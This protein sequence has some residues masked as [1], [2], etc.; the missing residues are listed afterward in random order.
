LQ[1]AKA[2]GNDKPTFAFG[3]VSA[4]LLSA[5]LLPQFYEIWK[6]KEV[7]GLSLTFMAVDLGGGV[8]CILSL[9]FKKT[10][11]PVATANYAGVVILDSLVLILAAI[12]NPRANRRRRREAEE[13]LGDAERGVAKVEHGPADLGGQNEDEKPGRV[14]VRDVPLED[15]GLVGSPMESRSITLCDQAGLSEAKA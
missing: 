15:S 6:F 8:F 14:S 3:L 7:K 5:A 1:N 2:A 11:D 12:L 4:I 10:I 13:S 9:A